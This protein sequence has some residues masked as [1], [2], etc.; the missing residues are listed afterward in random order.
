MVTRIIEHE[1]LR[2]HFNL[3]NVS[4]GTLTIMDRKKWFILVLIVT[5]EA[6]VLMKMIWFN[7]LTCKPTG[8]DI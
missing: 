3:I 2:E 5:H 7:E 8:Q 6:S 4:D 1:N